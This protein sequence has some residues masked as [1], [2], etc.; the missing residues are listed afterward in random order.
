MLQCSETI[1]IIFFIWKTIVN[2]TSWRLKNWSQTMHIIYFRRAGGTHK[3]WLLTDVYFI[4]ADLRKT[5]IKMSAIYVCNGQ[6]ITQTTM[7]Y[8]HWLLLCGRYVIVLPCVWYGWTKCIFVLKIR[9]GNTSFI[10]SQ[11]LIWL[12]RVCLFLNILHSPQRQII[13]VVWVKTKH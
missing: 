9:N 8:L 7:Q 5:W 2:R 10:V 11:F 12:R 4:N 13:C 6:Q 1:S 3:Q